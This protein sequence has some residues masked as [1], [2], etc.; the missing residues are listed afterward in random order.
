MLSAR[1]LAAL[2]TLSAMGTNLGCEGGACDNPQPRISV[3]FDVTAR[4]VD[5]NGAP[6]ADHPLEVDVYKIE[7]AQDTSRIEASPFTGTTDADGYYHVPMLVGYNMDDSE[8]G[9]GVTV[10]VHDPEG[11]VHQ[12]MSYQEL[13]PY[14]GTTRNLQVVIA[15]D[16]GS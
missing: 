16:T 1:A 9:A 5:Q 6:L 3:S 15:V 7:C 4:V 13:A 14:N 8:E 2:V 10:V 12:S 11:I